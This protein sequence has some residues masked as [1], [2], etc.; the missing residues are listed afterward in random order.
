M[1]IAIYCHS[2]APSIDGVCRRFTNILHELIL[3]NHEILLYTLEE[4]PEN[5]PSHSIQTIWLDY[6]LMPAYPNK[7]V[8]KP[9]ILTLYHI[10][11]SLHT[12]QPDVI[13]ITGDGISQLFAVMGLMLNIPVVGSFHT[14]I[15]DLL[16][17]HNANFFQ[18][19][20]IQFKESVDSFILDSCATTSESFAVRHNPPPTCPL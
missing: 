7:K 18:K 20:C 13:H 12:F 9:E 3:E 19:W 8:A 11:T 4:T 15:L 10:Y 16:V 6:F 14:D 1:K 17:S 5:L 2:I